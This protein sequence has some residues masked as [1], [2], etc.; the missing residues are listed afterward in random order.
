MIQFSWCTNQVLHVVESKSLA[1][2]FDSVSLP[3]GEVTLGQ[4]LQQQ[5]YCSG[6]L[7]ASS[8]LLM[9]SLWWSC[10]TIPALF[11]RASHLKRSFL[12]DD[13]LGPC[14]SQWE[15][16]VNKNYKGN[17]DLDGTFSLTDTD[18]ESADFEIEGSEGTPELFSPSEEEPPPDP[19]AFCER[20][21]ANTGG[22]AC[23]RPMLQRYWCRWGPYYLDQFLRSRVEHARR[24]LCWFCKEGPLGDIHLR[25]ASTLCGPPVP[26]RPISLQECPWSGWCLAEFWTRAS[27][28]EPTV[29][30]KRIPVRWSSSQRMRKRKPQKVILLLCKTHR[31]GPCGDDHWQ[32][33]SRGIW[34]DWPQ[35]FW[36]TG[37][38]H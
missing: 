17:P 3:C 15:K 8:R 21:P 38:N 14:E 5:P 23:V 2:K 31:L 13:D 37:R 29:G 24:M 20:V 22:F 4:F 12:L 6:W 27:G 35:T 33:T 25:F 18:L 19:K 30:S 9:G 16:S 1:I 36:F 26:L 28:F 7:L 11:S 32:L 34:A 10:A